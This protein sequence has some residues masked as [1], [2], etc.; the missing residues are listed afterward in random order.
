MGGGQESMTP[1]S[2][3]QNQTPY[4]GGI[5]RPSIMSIL[6]N[7][8]INVYTR[9]STRIRG[10]MSYFPNIYPINTNDYASLFGEGF[11]VFMCYRE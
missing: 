9:K 2:L 7:A 11:S 1:P 5:S 10:H 4:R 6:Q 3:F 8:V